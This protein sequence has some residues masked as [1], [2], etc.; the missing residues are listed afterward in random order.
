MYV[1]KGTLNISVRNINEF[2]ELL[3]KADEQSKE[4]RFTIDRLKSFDLKIEFENK[5]ETI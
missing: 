5:K 2:N 1:N 3:K 4:L